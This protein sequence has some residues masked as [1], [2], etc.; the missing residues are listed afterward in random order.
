MK[1]TTEQLENYEY[2]DG[3][4]FIKDEETLYKTFKSIHDTLIEEGFEREDIYNY[5]TLKTK[6]HL[7]NL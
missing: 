7:N 5:L 2:L 6:M 1:T 3:L 4:I